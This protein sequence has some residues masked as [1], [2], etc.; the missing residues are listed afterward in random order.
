[1][2]R[3]QDLAAVAGGLLAALGTVAVAGARRLRRRGLPAAWQGFLDATSEAVVVLDRRGVVRHWNAAAE[4]LFGW[5]ADAAIGHRID[6]LFVPAD[7]ATAYRPLLEGVLPRGMP[8]RAQVPAV[9]HDGSRWLLDVAAW[10]PAKNP[11]V[12]VHAAGGAQCAL[13]VPARWWER[14]RRT[15]VTARAV[16]VELDPVRREVWYGPEVEQVLGWRPEDVNG[17]IERSLG[18]VHADDLEPILQA[19]EEAIASRT[20]P[21]REYRW[22]RRDGSW[23]VLRAQGGW[24]DE[25]IAGLIVDVTERRHTDAGLSRFFEF[26]SDLVCVAGFDGRLRRTN[27]AFDRM[28]GTPGREGPSSLASVLAPDDESE[29]ERLRRWLASGEHLMQHTVRLQR[30]DGEPIWVEWHAVPC[31]MDEE[32][33]V[34]GR[35]VSARVVAQQELE[36]LGRRA[37]AAN[38]AKT[39]F[40]ASMSHEIR[41][42]LAAI[43]GY[44]ELAADDG[45]GD[46]ERREMLATILRNGKHLLDI[47]N[48]ILDLSK[49]EAGALDVERVPCSPAR[50]VDEVVALLRVRAADKGI[51]L[52]VAQ[53]AEIPE[54]VL[55]DPLRLRQILMNLVANAVKFTE[56][57]SV[58]VRLGMC[59]GRLRFEVEDTGIGMDPSTLSRLFQ[60]FTQAD[61]STSRRYGGTG[62]GLALTR[63]LANLLGAE[64]A[65]R[66]ELG[67]GSTFTVSLP[68]ERAPARPVAEA[69]DDSPA[70]ASSAATLRQ[71]CRVLVA[72]DSRDNQELIAHILRAAGAEVDVAST[73]R[74]ACERVAE[75]A[76]RGQL[77]DLVLM[78]VQMPELDGLEATAALRAAGHR[79][80]VIALS[81][82]VSRDEQDRCL[83]A[84]CDAF[85][86]KPIDRRAL[87]AT[88]ARYTT[89]LP[90]LVRQL[91][92]EDDETLEQLAREFAMRLPEVI[93]AL[94]RAIESNTT[95]ARRMVHKLKGSAGSFGYPE[96]TAAAARLEELLLADAG[97]EALQEPVQ[98]LRWL[99]ARAV[100]GLD[101]TP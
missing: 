69:D 60:P 56:E 33:Y 26:S 49:I 52:H 80:P 14:Y 92:T 23:A 91:D 98:Q 44:A 89:A 8:W 96:V 94:A 41:T 4:A 57:G 24:V 28:L 31:G 16:A 17:S 43:L 50:I 27:Q 25:V 87:V 95:E 85:L 12:V 20:V 21:T 58:T 35:D 62:L 47:V 42:P 45:I 67:R 83:A 55:S 101:G 76:A 5:P 3:M 99:G 22:R 75:A 61:S 2:A 72:E 13:P 100:A 86:A 93:D 1:M 77:Y 53:D 11:W 64:I 48:D 39:E 18:F 71:G 74:V 66:S 65:V 97:D 36:Q 88:V 79:L 6:A 84:G 82:G 34:V 54:A 90:P 32:I 37:D 46:E 70:A 51:G 40:L 30:R 78:D 29:A 81:A 10:S 9:R 19:V 59:D 73:G 15:H 38:R 68:A 7:A 63:R